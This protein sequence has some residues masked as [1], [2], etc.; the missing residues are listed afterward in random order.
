MP[1]ASR[2]DSTSVLHS[3]T[4][5]FWR[6][7]LVNMLL[8]FPKQ[9]SISQGP[10]VS[11][12]FPKTLPWP[13]FA[14]APR[15]FHLPRSNHL[16]PHCHEGVHQHLERRGTCMSRQRRHTSTWV[17]CLRCLHRVL[18]EVAARQP[19]HIVTS[20]FGSAMQLSSCLQRSLSDYSEVDLSFMFWIAASLTLSLRLVGP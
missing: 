2:V 12:F 8:S 7:V 6:R 17:I 1:I 11:F 16:T 4:E 13:S 3:A 5:R 9:K 20:A 15:H 14:Q 19:G 18:Q 10:T